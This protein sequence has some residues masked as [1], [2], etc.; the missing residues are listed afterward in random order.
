MNQA[1]SLL[2]P[3]TAVSTRITPQQRGVSGLAYCVPFER[4]G[5]KNVEQ[6]FGGNAAQLIINTALN[7]AAGLQTYEIGGGSIGAGAIISFLTALDNFINRKRLEEQYIQ[8]VISSY[9]AKQE[10]MIWMLDCHF[11]YCEIAPII[12]NVSDP[13]LNIDELRY[14]LIQQFITITEVANY[15]RWEK[16]THYQSVSK[17]VE[18]PDDL[19]PIGEFIDMELAGNIMIGVNE[20]SAYWLGD[21]IRF[22][23]I[24]GDEFKVL[25]RYGH[26]KEWQKASHRMRDKR[27]ICKGAYE[28]SDDFSCKE[29]WNLGNMSGSGFLILD[30]KYRDYAGGLKLQDTIQ[31]S[32]PGPPPGLT[33]PQ[34]PE[35]PEP[36]QNPFSLL[37]LIPNT[38]VAGFFS[39]LFNIDLFNVDKLKETFNISSITQKI[40]EMD[41]IQALKIAGGVLLAGTAI[42]LAWQAISGE[43]QKYVKPLSGTGKRKQQKKIT[44]ANLK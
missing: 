24:P 10:A 38:R 18:V 4:F 14:D 41:K 16:L 11:P 33:I 3:F 12:T 43:S 39:D 2:M 5:G 37:T 6:Q 13:A 42:F 29:G 9:E 30:K 17:V 35:V 44:T 21:I 40:K 32:K 23:N 34:V 20:V 1:S 31:L 28:R 22:T 36:D 27:F 8:T 7:Y 15:I 25:M 19:F 26:T